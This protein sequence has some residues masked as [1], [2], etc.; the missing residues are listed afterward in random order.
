[1]EPEVFLIAGAMAA[2]KTTVARL[3]AARFERGVH[4]E[5]DTFRRNIV[6]GRID[7]TPDL[8]PAAVAQ[9]R[10]RYRLAATSADAYVDAGFTVALEDVV[11]GPMLAEYAGLI[12]SPLHV[13]VLCPSLHEIRARDE[14]RSH[15]GYGLWSPEQLHDVLE[16]Q[17][18]R[19]GRW[20][21]NSNLTAE[22]TVE[23]ILAQ[24]V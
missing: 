6:R 12:R 15:H 11:V 21:D 4:I 22:E 10:L 5:G 24:V 20:L 7:P 3:L 18:P 1:V 23:E 8:A 2:G 17:T 14:T 9:L 19:I 13:V 16:R